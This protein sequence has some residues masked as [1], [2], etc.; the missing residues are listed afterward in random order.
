MSSY[1]AFCTPVIIKYLGK[2]CRTGFHLNWLAHVGHGL[3]R[4][5]P[6]ERSGNAQYN[7]H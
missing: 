1:D 7:K 3:R 4:G 6:V 5:N 2:S